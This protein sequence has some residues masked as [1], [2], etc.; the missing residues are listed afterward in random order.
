MKQSTPGSQSAT[1]TLLLLS[2]LI[3]TAPSTHAVDNSITEESP[4][5]SR[6]DRRNLR[7]L[8]YGLIGPIND[9]QWSQG[10]QGSGAKAVIFDPDSREEPIRSRTRPFN[11][12]GA[13]IDNSTGDISVE[14]LF[15]DP[16]PQKILNFNGS[17]IN[18]L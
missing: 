16:D 5:Y 17:T 14:E 2:L 8:G 13:Y 7:D 4:N 6:S 9:V 11:S 18:N 10:S 3:L 12:G 1:Y 15:G